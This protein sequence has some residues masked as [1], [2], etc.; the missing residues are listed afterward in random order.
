MQLNYDKQYF[1]TQ[2]CMDYVAEG[3]MFVINNNTFYLNV[4]NVIM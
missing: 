2:N 1:N 4:N 3:K